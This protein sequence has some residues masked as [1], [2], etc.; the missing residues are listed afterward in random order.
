MQEDVLNEERCIDSCP[1][2]SSMEP[3]RLAER[4][5]ASL[6]MRDITEREHEGRMGH[7]APRNLLGQETHIARPERKR[8]KLS[9]AMLTWRF[10]TFRDH[11]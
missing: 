8:Q 6:E 2:F 5:L 10:K 9:T 3:G 4:N 1:I 7:H 11:A